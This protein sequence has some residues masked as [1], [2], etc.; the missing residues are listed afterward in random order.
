MSLGRALVIYT[1]L[2]AAGAL[3]GRFEHMATPVAVAA[4]VVGAVLMLSG[5]VMRLLD[6]IALESL[7][8]K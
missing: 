5:A 7:M 2:A 1:A 6:N 8:S 4:V 3:G